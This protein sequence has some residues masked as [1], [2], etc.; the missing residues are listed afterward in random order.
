[1]IRA[2][3]STS[4]IVHL[5]DIHPS[6]KHVCVAGGSSGTVSVWD[7]LWQQQP[8]LLSIRGLEGS[9]RFLHAVSEC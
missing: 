5:I 8:F 2:H 1:M 3:G 7:L 9:I 6:R 4:G